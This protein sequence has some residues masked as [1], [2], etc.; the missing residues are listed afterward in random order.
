MVP[1]EHAIGAV[2]DDDVAV[3]IPC[4]GYGNIL[5]DAIESAL[6]Q[7]HPAA[8]ILVVDDGSPDETR[9]VAESYAARGV[10]YVWQAN[11]GPGAARNT[12]IAASKAPLTIF[13]DADDKLDPTY[14]EKTL[15]VLAGSA[16]DVGYVYT[17]VRYFG[18]EEGKTTHYPQWDAQR[19]LRWPFVH[20]SALIRSALVRAY[21]YDERRGP[22][23][24][25]WD[26]FLTLAE[27]GVRG[28]LLDE[29][30]LWYRRHH[31]TSRSDQTDER[32]FHAVLRKHW[33]LGGIAHAARIEAYYL[34]QRIVRGRL[35][36][37]RGADG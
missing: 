15:A 35:T 11:G 9:A 3:V 36:D 12:G 8:D 29:P 31:G 33:R 14:I 18:A 27:H 13:L 1:L 26:L 21:P 4:Y 22:W 2:M 17:Q 20:P 23:I 25:D 37:A 19:L 32:A 30:L 24:E 5:A 16:D 10:R 28:V 6:Q 7:T 34:K